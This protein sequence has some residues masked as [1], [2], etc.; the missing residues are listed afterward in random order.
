MRKKAAVRNNYGIVL[1]CDAFECCF[2]IWIVD[3]DVFC[4]TTNFVLPQ[5]L[6]C[7]TVLSA[8]QE[9]GSSQAYLIIYVKSVRTCKSG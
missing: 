3:R 7:I 4:V 6:P 1:L 5:S 8:W 2:D 9:V